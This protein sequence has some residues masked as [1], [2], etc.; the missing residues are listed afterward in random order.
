[1]RTGAWKAEAGG[2]KFRVDPDPEDAN[3]SSGIGPA[4]FL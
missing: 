2:T 4:L 1:M 3:T